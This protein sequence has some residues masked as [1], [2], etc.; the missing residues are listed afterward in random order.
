MR[1]TSWAIC[2]ARSRKRFQ[3]LPGVETVGISSYTPMEDDN[4]MW[5][6]RVQG[7]PNLHLG[8]SFIKANAEYFDSVGTRVVMGARDHGAG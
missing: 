5:G 7:K 8:A 2:I 1:S 6:V 4:N 3:A